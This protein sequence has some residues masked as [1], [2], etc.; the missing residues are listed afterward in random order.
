[1]N[2]DRPPPDRK[3]ALDAIRQ[4]VIVDLPLMPDPPSER[5]SA[6]DPDDL[7]ARLASDSVLMAAW[8]SVREA[9]LEDGH[10]SQAGRRFERDALTN[11][12]RLRASLYDG[13]WRP[14]PVS[15]FAAPAEPTRMLTVSALEDRIVERALADVLG[16]RIDTGLS[17]YC[18]AYRRGLG[19]RDAVTALRESM[20]GGATHVARADVRHAFDEVPRRKSIESL[21]AHVPDQ[22][23][24]A[25]V[26]HLLARLDDDGLD[27]LGIPQGSAVSP[28]LLNLYL[29][30]LDL[31]LLDKGFVPIRYADD[32]A[33]PVDSEKEG[34]TV[35]R[36]VS[37]FL[38]QLALELNAQ[39]CRVE[40]VASGVDFL[41][42]RIGP[43]G[44]PDPADQHVHPRRM[45]LYVMGHGS[46]ARL[47]AGHIRVMRDGQTTASVSLNR[48]RSI[49]LGGSAH[50]TTPLLRAA[51]HKGIE[52]FLL[53]DAG[54]YEGRVS[55]RR[56]G[57][58]R[59]RQAQ[60]RAADDPD[61]T[62]SIARQI[63]ADKIANM[64]VLILR[65]LRRRGRSDQGSKSRVARELEGWAHHALT[66][67][68][69][70]SLMG[71]EGIAARVY[72]AWLSDVIPGDWGFAGRNRRPPRD[73]VNA[74][75]SYCYT[76]LTGEVISAVE[77]AGLDPDLGFLHSPRWG[78]PALALDLVEPWRPVLTDAT[79]LTLIRSGSIG[80]EDFLSDQDSGCRMSD[81]ARKALL[82]AY[83]RRML[84]PAGS[85]EV[86]GKRPY[87][88]L[89]TE[90]A[91]GLADH[92]VDP[93]E[94]FGSFQWR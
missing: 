11:L 19:V 90:F 92:L 4:T 48:V 6:I 39:K 58:V 79:V 59:V 80:P 47:A 14:G 27:G 35:L 91:R 44:T 2:V 76:L 67:A 45:S 33:I 94:G 86:R 7:L 83:E 20:A 85:A 73:P 18:F 34:W 71:I 43:L 32:L 63:V 78:R 65:D 26:E 68:T 15:R 66:A 87:R 8:V 3:A 72:F 81:K 64:R 57:D 23:V 24:T 10:Q 51:A 88:E 25:I 84:T 13:S 75:L 28:I 21:A 89:L 74:M 53:D 1:M 17:P 54:Q 31:F 52:V 55:R 49:V 56:G 40:A 46:L 50:A 60:F 77:I 70:H 30:P 38:G 9:D 93:V 69:H 16:P 22:R 37:E 5:R 61:L 41:G 36:E 29:S 62:L 42:Q 82:V 12:T